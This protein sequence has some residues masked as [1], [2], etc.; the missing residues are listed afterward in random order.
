V[1]FEKDCGVQKSQLWVA[2]S[3]V[4]V[5]VTLGGRARSESRVC[6]LHY[7]LSHIFFRHLRNSNRVVGRSIIGVHSIKVRLHDKTFI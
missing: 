1:I 6:N 3:I 2:S 5:R 7:E 4:H